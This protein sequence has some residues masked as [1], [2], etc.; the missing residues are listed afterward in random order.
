MNKI[1]YKEG[2]NINNKHDYIIKYLKLDT[3]TTYYKHNNF[4]QCRERKARTFNDLLWLLQSKFKTATKG[5]LARILLHKNNMN[6]VGC[7]PCS[8]VKQMTFYSTNNKK[9]GHYAFHYKYSKHD[10]IEKGPQW[11]DLVKWAT[12]KKDFELPQE[13]ILKDIDEHIKPVKKLFIE[14]LKEQGV[15]KQFIKNL[16]RRNKFKSLT[17]FLNNNHQ[18]NK[19]VISAFSWRENNDNISWSE[20]DGLWRAKVDLYENNVNYLF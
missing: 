3:P 2:K 12:R 4:V 19:W 7:V 13:Y 9:Y 17:S 18:V 5:D 1:Y 8:D 10:I 11:A 6:I 14:F 16:K 15:Y 20:I